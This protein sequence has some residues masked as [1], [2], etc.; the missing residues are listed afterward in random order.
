[1]NTKIL[2]KYIILYNYYNIKTRAGN[3]ILIT[4]TLEKLYSFVGNKNKYIIDIG[5]STC[6]INDP[7]YKFITN[8]E[9]KG[10]CIEGNKDNIE[11][12]KQGIANTFE[13]YDNYIYPDTILEVFEKFN[14]PIELDILKIDIDG[15]DLEV[16]RSILGKYKPKIIIAEYNEKIPPP[17]LFE[18]K[19]KK[20]Y[21]WD[22][23]HCFGFSI[24]SGKKVMDNYNYTIIKIFELNNI[25]C[26][27]ND[28]CEQLNISKTNIYDI[29][30]KEYELNPRRFR[31]LPWNENVNYWL[32]IK[33]V[34]ILYSEILNYFT[35]NNNK[36]LDI[37]FILKIDN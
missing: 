1:M 18:I 21:E 24:C 33:D 34:N 26:I 16:L 4:M 23:S 32:T 14:V 25:L 36:I 35:K 31:M 15:F 37:D 29:Y 8:N 7:V 30:N 17:I 27:Q 9:Y 20:D 6:S 19:Y 28:I 5:A 13:I 10:L 3:N 2:Y 22:Y 12:L 11:K